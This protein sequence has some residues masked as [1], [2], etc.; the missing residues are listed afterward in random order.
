MIIIT[1]PYSPTPTLPY[2]PPPKGLA[3]LLAYSRAL[4]LRTHFILFF[5]HFGCKNSFV[6]WSLRSEDGGSVCNHELGWQTCVCCLHRAPEPHS[7]SLSPTSPGEWVPAS[8]LIYI[9]I[10]VCLSFYLEKKKKN[11]CLCPDTSGHAP[12]TPAASR[13]S[14]LWRTRGQ[15]DVSRPFRDI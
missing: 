15:H 5:S 9:V 13:C 3:K 4:K 10:R 8:Q 6:L 12:A 14:S 1:L 2:L 11:E 7:Q